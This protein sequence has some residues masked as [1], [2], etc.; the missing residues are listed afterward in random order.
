[1]VTLAKALEHRLRVRWGGA[2]G[3]RGREPFVVVIVASG[4]GPLDAQDKTWRAVRGRHLARGLRRGVVYPLRGSLDAVPP[5]QGHGE[6][7]VTSVVHLYGPRLVG[8][9][10]GTPGVGGIGGGAGRLQL[11]SLS[12]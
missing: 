8:G 5:L 1:M 9:V 7:V 3:G 10:A 11:L 12:L 6:G 2:D 4:D